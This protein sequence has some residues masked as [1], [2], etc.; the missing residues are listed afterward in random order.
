MKEYQ[1][2]PEKL[3]RRRLTTFGA[4][5]LAFA[6]AITQIAPAYADITNQ[7]QA[8]G[9]NAAADDTTANS[10]VIN[11]PVGA[12]NPVLNTVKSVSSGP[13][14]AAGETGVV[15]GGD[16]IT[17][18]YV[19]TNN[20]NV[21][22]SGVAPVEAAAPTFN[23]TAGT[24]ANYCSSF[25]LTAGTTTLAPTQSATFTCAYTLTAL[26]AYR[27]AGITNGVS[28][29]ASATGTPARGSLSA[30]NSA[31]ATAT[32][33]ANSKLKITKSVVNGPGTPSPGGATGANAN[34]GDFIQYRY[35]VEN[36]GNVQLTNINV[37][38]TH[39]GTA[40]PAGTVANE[41]IVS[42]GVQTGS[43]DDATPNNGNWATLKAGAT[44][45]FFYIHTVNITEFNNG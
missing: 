26:D 16:T 4:S 7:A 8:R 19:I 28:N 31:A 44:M 35:F 13:T 37:I 11:V 14:T 45:E 33:P 1:D 29:I 39:E 38:D 25:T 41:A 6:A 17:F 10:A 40:L 42:Q 43:V 27:A 21:T 9:T 5:S 18:Q 34:V 24:L 23:G 22:I 36:V 2:L 3:R 32:I 20:G 12:P 30:P 15:D